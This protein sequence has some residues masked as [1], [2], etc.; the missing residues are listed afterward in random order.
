MQHVYAERA[1][2]GTRL[3]EGVELAINDSGVIE[4]VREAPGTPEP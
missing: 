2:I 3:V 4:D 1:V